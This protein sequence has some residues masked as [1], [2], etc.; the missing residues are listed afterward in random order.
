MIFYT[1]LSTMLWCNKSHW[2]LY[3]ILPGSRIQLQLLFIHSFKC[4]RMVY[5]IYINMLNSEELAQYLI[6]CIS[7]YNSYNLELSQKMN[8][9]INCFLNIKLLF[10]KYLTQQ[11]FEFDKQLKWRQILLQLET[12]TVYVELLWILWYQLHINSIQHCE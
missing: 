4:W 11:A 12:M 7:S 2:T 5:P 3:G 9:C 10:Y 1:Q 8:I 6:V